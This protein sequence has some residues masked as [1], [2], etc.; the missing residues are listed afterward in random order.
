M[1][2]IDPPRARRTPD[3][4]ADELRRR[5]PLDTGPYR[6]PARHPFVQPRVYF[7]GLPYPQ[8]LSWL[9]ERDEN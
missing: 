3:V 5:D 7:D 6:S 1:A 9:D 2:D 4:T 8:R